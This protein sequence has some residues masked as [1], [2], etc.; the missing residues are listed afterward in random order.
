MLPLALAATF[1]LAGCGGSSDG[2]ATP[3][4]APSDAGATDTTVAVTTT[5]VATTEETIAASADVGS[6]GCDRVLTSDEV[7][8]ILGSPVE[9]TGSSETCM[10]IFADDSIGNLQAFSG[11]K[12]DEAIEVLLGK[13][14]AD[15]AAS[16]SGVLLD[17]G[18]GFV[19]D[20]SAIVRGDSG[21]VFRFDTP[22]NV[23]VPDM[24]L[25]MEAIAALLLT[26]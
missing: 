16:A 12:A 8:S 18:R 25:A 19:L 14:Q 13:F 26:R 11:S 4:A 24:Q 1:V 21:R 2:G 5:T 6:D 17:D 7:E 3:S 9:F 20:G 10:V 23:D 15:E 22:D